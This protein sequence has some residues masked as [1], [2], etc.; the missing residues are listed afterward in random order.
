MGKLKSKK[1]ASNITD[2]FIRVLSYVGILGKVNKKQ[3][4][5]RVG[6]LKTL[7]GSTN[8]SP[9]ELDSFLN[10]SVDKSSEH[11]KRTD[12]MAKERQDK[13]SEIYDVQELPAGLNVIKGRKI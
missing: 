6:I 8:M 13:E 11:Y 10:Y 1:E 12:V 7:E 4:E 5:D 2:P 3:R 9:E